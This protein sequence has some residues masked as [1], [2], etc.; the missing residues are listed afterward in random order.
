VEDPGLPFTCSVLVDADVQPGHAYVEVGG[1]R[2]DVGTEARKALVFSA[3]G[4]NPSDSS[5][6]SPP[7]VWRLQ[8]S[9]PY[10]RAIRSMSPLLTEFQS[11]VASPK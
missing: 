8:S 11:R 4:L 5:A 7:E 10:S 2:I 9:L 6:K 3:L 1:A